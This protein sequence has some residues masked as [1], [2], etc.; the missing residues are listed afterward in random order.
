MTLQQLRYVVEI[1]KY[2]SI[3]KSASNL[4]ISQPNL[5]AA[6]KDLE[7]ELDIIVFVRT[8]KG[9]EPTE[10]GREFLSYAK[11]VIAQVDRM[12]F[13]FKNKQGKKVVLN[14]ACTRSSY[15][16]KVICDFY[17]Q[18]PND[19]PVNLKFIESNSKNVVS[20]VASSN[21]DF[22]RIVF[23]EE[24][25]PFYKRLVQKS[26]LVMEILWKVK[27]YVLT[28]E[29]SDLAQRTDLSADDLS[30]YTR[31]IYCDFEEDI[32]SN[33]DIDNFI[34]LNER[35]SMLEVL[36]SC[37]DCYLWTISTHP[38]TLKD[39][40]L[41]PVPVK[42]APFIYE[43]LIYPKDRPRTEEVQWLLGHM[44][45]LKYTEYFQFQEP[46]HPETVL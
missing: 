12:E 6:L 36:S 14:I 40:R 19:I 21:A 35:G 43:A 27:A 22:G 10:E 5:S 17:N 20:A 33:E 16:T 7:Q 18:L 39:H 13:M 44:K 45:S 11:S 31:C 23:G 30:E 42:N 4:F 3:T 29:E 26:R 24:Y 37:P 9:V 15:A 34:A 25:M 38:D 32:I 28:S 1:E 46:F 41:V 2:G 8:S